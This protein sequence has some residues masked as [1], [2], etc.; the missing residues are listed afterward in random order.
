MKSRCWFFS[1]R[2]EPFDWNAGKT[3]EYGYAHRLWC[4]E[5]RMVRFTCTRGGW[6]GKGWTCPMP[7]T[8]PPSKTPLH[9]GICLTR[10]ILCIVPVCATKK[11]TFLW[12]TQELLVL[13]QDLRKF[14]IDID[15]FPIAAAVRM[16]M[17]IPI[18][19][20]P[21]SPFIVIADDIRME[22]SRFPFAFS[23]WSLS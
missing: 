8:P 23:I 7:L 10:F 18:F 11:V 17:S 5:T 6:S 12:L 3:V 4:M 14:H 15:S 19:Y 22:R 9:R 2:K 20:E 16:S 1:I 13:P 21:Y